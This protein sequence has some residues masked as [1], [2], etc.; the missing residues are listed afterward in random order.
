M[1]RTLRFQRKRVLLQSPLGFN[2]KENDGGRETRKVGGPPVE[3]LNQEEMVLKLGCPEV[4]RKG[5]ENS[6]LAPLPV[7][8]QCLPLPET[9]W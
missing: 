1:V 7:F 2:V 6:Q 3:D 4:Q 8:C 5:K 9:T